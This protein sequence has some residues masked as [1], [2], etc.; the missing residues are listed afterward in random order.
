M[1][2]GLIEERV[3]GNREDR[4]TGAYWLLDGSDVRSRN[5]N[6]S[7]TSTN[8]ACE[9]AEKCNQ[10]LPGGLGGFPP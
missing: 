8:H 4:L 10:G 6:L 7:V 3:E 9:F 1:H 2:S 5:G